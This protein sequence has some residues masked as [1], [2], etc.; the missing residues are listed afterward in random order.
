LDGFEQERNLMMVITVGIFEG[1]PKRLGV[2]GSVEWA[3][4]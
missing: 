3:I 4:A 2:D 1:L